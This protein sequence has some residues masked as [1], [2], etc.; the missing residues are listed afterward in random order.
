MEIRIDEHPEKRKYNTR[1][2][3]KGVKAHENNIKLIGFEKR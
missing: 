1:K 2:I 3:G